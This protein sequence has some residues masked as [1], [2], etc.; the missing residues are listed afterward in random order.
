MAQVQLGPIVSQIAGSVAGSTFQ[1]GASGFQLRRKPLP[2]LRRTKPASSQRQWMGFL[3]RY[4]STLSAFQREQWAEA[5]AL[6]SWANKFGDP[7]T[8]H[9]YWLFLRCNSYLHSVDVHHIDEPTVTFPFEPVSAFTVG[10]YV[11]RKLE[12]TAVAPNPTQSDTVLQV[13]AS[14]Q[15]SP[16][17]QYPGASLR[18]IRNLGGTISTPFDLYEY[19]TR[20]FPPDLVAGRVIWFQVQAIDKAGGYAGPRTLW[21]VTVQP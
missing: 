6:L 1:R 18:F 17:L 14:P 10:A 16:G 13:S 21:P 3:S 5:A 15:L 19:Y 8:G 7:I 4:W 11:P 20:V 9:G 12:L 2:I